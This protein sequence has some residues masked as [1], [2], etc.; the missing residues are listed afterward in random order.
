MNWLNNYYVMKI[1]QMFVVF[2]VYSGSFLFFHQVPQ[3]EK[4]SG[5]EGGEED[6]N[7]SC[8]LPSWKCFTS[9]NYVTISYSLLA[10]C[11]LS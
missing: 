4:K 6:S 9:V 11:L 8:I 5:S 2:L 1:F 10:K 7:S 3:V